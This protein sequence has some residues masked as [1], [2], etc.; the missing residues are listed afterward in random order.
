MIGT[1]LF[2]IIGWQIIYVFI[3]GYPTFWGGNIYWPNFAI[4][5]QFMAGVLYLFSIKKIRA[6]K[7]KVT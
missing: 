7:E 5:L 6:K 2:L 4:F 3:I 1:P